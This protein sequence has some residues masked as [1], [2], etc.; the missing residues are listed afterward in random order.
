[1]I[2]PG[3]QHEIRVARRL[4][5]P[6]GSVLVFDRGYTDYDWFAA[7]SRQKVFFVTRLK[8]QADFMRN[9]LK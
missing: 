8:E 3:K 6:P 5:L 2:T 4:K 1:M 7:L 9:R